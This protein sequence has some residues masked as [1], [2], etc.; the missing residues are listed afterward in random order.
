[1]SSVQQNIIS[2]QLLKFNGI[3]PSDFVHQPRSISEL[4][5]WKA[6]ML[7]SFLLNTGLVALK[8]V[9]SKQSYKHFLSYLLAIQMLC[10]KN[11]IKR[12][13]IIE[14]AS[15]LL[16]YFVKNSKEHHGSSFNVYNVHG[17]LHIDDD[18]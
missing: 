7:R 2:K 3:L 8:G 5:W 13:S 4:N 14:S 11:T 10:E 16:N 1:M 9:L 12:N 17:L 6:T 15:Q 18:V